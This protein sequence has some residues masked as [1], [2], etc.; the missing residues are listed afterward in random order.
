MSTLAYAALTTRRLQ[1]APG[2][3]TSTSPPGVQTYVDAVAA[4]VPAEVLAL[5][6]VIVSLTTST[7]DSV[8]RISAPDVLR[9]A[10]WALI[11][12]SVVLY[13]VPRFKTRER[14]DVLRA[15]IP[16][17]AFVAW[18]MLQ[19]VTAFDAV[20]PGLKDPGRTVY[21]LLAAV[22]LGIVAGSLANRA[23]KA[24]PPARR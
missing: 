21:A 5:H 4:L 20:F 19:R 23:D 6:A 16:P 10:F 22:I 17:L 1:G 11:A 18:T 24:A 3:T 7:A 2:T 8:T 12:L 9:V 15:A 13:C 14:L